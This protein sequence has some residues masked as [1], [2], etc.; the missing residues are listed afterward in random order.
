MKN[1]IINACPSKSKPRWYEIS[2]CIEQCQGDDQHYSSNIHLK[3]F[4]ALIVHVED[5]RTTYP[6]YGRFGMWKYKFLVLIIESR[7]YDYPKIGI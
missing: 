6:K 2:S 1:K 3:G 5:I 4:S 7:K